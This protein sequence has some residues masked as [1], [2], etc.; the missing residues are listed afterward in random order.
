MRCT[1][2]VSISA[3]SRDEVR[4]VEAAL[5]ENDAVGLDHRN[6]CSERG[7]QIGGPID[8]DDRGARRMEGEPLLGALAEVAS[9]SGIEHDWHASGRMRE[10]SEA[11]SR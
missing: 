2:A 11:A 9:A 1:A 3:Y 6:P 5:D 8:V 4:L 7:D 10:T